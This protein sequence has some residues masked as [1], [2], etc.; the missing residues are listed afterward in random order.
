MEATITAP[1]TSSYNNNDGH[2]Y[3]VSITATDDGGNNTTIDDTHE[4]LGESLKLRVKEKVAPT[5]TITAP[6]AG[7]TITNNKPGNYSTVAR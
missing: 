6:T 1:S 4:T 3:P 2:Y 7:A 5:I